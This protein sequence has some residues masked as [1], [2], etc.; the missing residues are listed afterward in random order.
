[1]NASAKPRQTA[2]TPGWAAFL[3]CAIALALTLAGCGG[4]NDSGATKT[5]T[6]FCAASVQPPVEALLSRYESEFGVRVEVQYGGSGTLLSNL[7]IAKL[8]DLYLAADSSYTDIARNEGLL[9][10]VLPLARLA[11]VIA[12]PKDNPRL[13]EDL[14]DLLNPGVRLALG[15]PEAASIGK[16]TREL[17]RASGHW[18]AIKRQAEKDGVFMPTVSELANA[19]FLGAVDAAIIWDA[20]ARQY[21]NLQMIVDPVLAAQTHTVSIG[22]L[23]SSNDAS[24]ALHLARFLASETG[25]ATF[26]AHGFQTISSDLQAEISPTIVSYAMTQHLPCPHFGQYVLREDR[27]LSALA[28]AGRFSAAASRKINEKQTLETL[29]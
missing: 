3:L 1:M 27:F 26:E 17:L 23:N 13:I 10:E 9:A 28:E 4:S 11:A 14:D 21:A 20:T 19:V 12:L 8:G 18:S 16:Q 25:K 6:L 22:L 15:N 24:A 29:L 7:K 5:L 2:L